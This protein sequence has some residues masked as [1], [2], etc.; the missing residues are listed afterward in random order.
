MYLFYFSFNFILGLGILFVCMNTVCTP[1]A[2]RGQKKA[3][4][5]LKEKTQR[6]MGHHRGAGNR[7]QVLLQKQQVFLTPSPGSLCCEGHWRSEGVKQVLA[8]P[9]SH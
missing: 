8:Q 2:C 3:L 6:V 7:I 9:A 5:P 1:G 4:D